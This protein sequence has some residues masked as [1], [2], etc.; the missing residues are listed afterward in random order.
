MGWN[1]YLRRLEWGFGWVSAEVFRYETR[2]VGI[3]WGFRN[4]THPRLQPITQHIQEVNIKVLGIKDVWVAATEVKILNTYFDEM[5]QYYRWRE[6]HLNGVTVLLNLKVL[7]GAKTQ[8]VYRVKKKEGMTDIHRG[9]ISQ[10][11]WMVRKKESHIRPSGII[12]RL[13]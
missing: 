12:E 10:Y 11:S 7:K 8:R 6:T 4:P 9:Y 3:D 1:T 2:T 5:W 13:C